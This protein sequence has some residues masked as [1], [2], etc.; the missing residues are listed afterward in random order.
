[1]DARRAPVL[2]WTAAPRTVPLADGTVVLVRGARTAD[3]DAAALLHGRCSPETVYR[4]YLTAVPQ[5]SR[6]WQRRL[7]LTEV[8]LTV[9]D[10]RR[11]VALLNASP[12]GDGEADLAVL[13]ED[14]YQGRGLGTLLVRHAAGVARL[15]RH[16][17]VRALT[18]PSSYA[19]RRVLAAA[20][21]AAWEEPGD[22]T[23][24]GRLLLGTGSLGGLIEPDDPPVRPPRP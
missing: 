13:V 3:A 1:M 17:A 16:R 14:A 11:M 7:L 18:L 19:A 21:A 23:L 9:W 6:S 24:V 20:G 22:G 2:T 15:L 8:A 12:R 10:G 5:V 4:R